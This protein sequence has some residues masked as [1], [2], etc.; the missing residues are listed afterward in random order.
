MP[1]P[2]LCSN[3][4]VSGVFGSIVGTSPS[5]GHWTNTPK[6][7]VPYNPVWIGAK[8]YSQTVCID[9]NQTGGVIPVCVSRGEENVIPALGPAPYPVSSIYT[10]GSSSAT[11]GS[12]QK[13]SILITQIN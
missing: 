11:S 9:A 3:L 1:I 13:G 5:S 10:V 7:E 2:G 6:F 4:Y 8:V 12:V